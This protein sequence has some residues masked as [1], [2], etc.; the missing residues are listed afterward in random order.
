[1]GSYAPNNQEEYPPG[2][3]PTSNYD[4]TN[5][6]STYSTNTNTTS[7]QHQDSVTSPP[8]KVT[9]NPH[10]TSSTASHQHQQEQELLSGYT[11]PNPP[12]STQQSTAIASEQDPGSGA[13]L[14]KP[15]TLWMGD[16]DPWL[17]EKGIQDLWWSILQKKV[18]IKII[19]PKNPKSDPTFHGL[20]NSGYCFVEFETFED[21]QQA[22][23]LNGQLLPDIAMPSQQHFP[24]N[25][26]NQKKYFR[27]NWAS[28]A[29]L[30][31]PIVQTPEFSLFVGDLSASTTEAHLLAFF[32]KSFPNSI[33][34]VRVMTDPISGKSRCFGFV[35]FTEELERQR[36]LVEMNG[37]WFA[38]RPLRVALATPRTTGR[39]F[40]NNH[41]LPYFQHQQHQH[42]PHTQ[43]SAPP[44]LGQP[45][46]TMGG[47]DYFNI[48]PS[49][50]PPPQSGSRGGGGPPPPEMM[51]MAPPPVGPNGSSPMYAYYGQGAP[52]QD[53]EGL[54]LDLGGSPNP[55]LLQQQQ[56][57][58]Q[59]Q[60]QQQF[61]DPNNTTVFVGG[62]SSEVN[63]PTLY[64]L[65]KPFGM[66]QQVKIPPGKNCGFVKYSTREEAEE[67]IAAMQGFIIGG[68]RVRLSWGRVS[69]S[70]KK[71]QQ[72]QHQVAHA[73]QMQVAAALSMGMDPASAIAAA[74]A[75]AAGGYPPNMAP[76]GAPPGV[77]PPSQHAAQVAAGM[78][79]GM[80]G[81]SPVPPPT[82]GVGAGGVPPNMGSMNIPP[83]PP[84]MHGMGL[85][86]MPQF[87][88]LPPHH[89]HQYSSDEGSGSADT[90]GTG[91]DNNNHNHGNND[92]NRNMPPSVFLGDVGGI[93][94][95]L[96]GSGDQYVGDLTNAMGGMSLGDTREGGAG[97]GYMMPSGYG[98]YG[99]AD[100]SQYQ[101]LF[102]EEEGRD[103]EEEREYEEEGEEED[104]D[105]DGDETEDI[106]GKEA[107]EEAGQEEKGE[108]E[109]EEEEAKE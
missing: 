95:G 104:R 103:Y 87:Q 108:D 54:N 22:L 97:Y 1:M 76:P 7:P 85:P 83:P 109:K 74:A 96:G 105:G 47:N 36:A 32:Q 63:E 66:I 56:R 15:R 69:M 41:Q 65:F 73:A 37:V 4:T 39:R 86:M 77:P 26:D 80:S 2:G 8:S 52:G 21:A 61:A 45:P 44:L 6:L 78:P 23:S 106:N 42:Q 62:L 58:P 51:F 107:E 29:T 27:L 81:V 20:T 3:T 25:P 38:G 40:H 82:G 70:N 34:T 88:G 14:D 5:P 94:G 33:K 92:N 89:T 72:Q 49:S 10:T 75:A 91:Y 84:P 64:T 11:V 31:A 35:R 57:Q 71:Y 18:T 50:A 99:L 98:G 13:E 53:L 43:Q 30:S 79:G 93:P 24:N 100:M 16:L 9:I 68:N 48:D 67:A 46:P 59:Q 102:P 55:A 60:Q 28:G 12:V 90:S 19:K 101:Q 17:D